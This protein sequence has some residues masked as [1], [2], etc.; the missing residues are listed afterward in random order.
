MK[1]SSFLINDRDRGGGE[2]AEPELNKKNFSK[3]FPI[4]GKS[5]IEW[6]F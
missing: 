3:E 4:T 6:K 1:L 2:R 5:F